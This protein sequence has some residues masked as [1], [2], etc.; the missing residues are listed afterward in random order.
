M[1]AFI[2]NTQTASIVGFALS[3]A[4]AAE[5][6]GENLVVSVST[7]LEGLTNT[8]LTTLYNAFTGETKNQFKTSKSD[9][10]K[11][12]FAALEAM[13]IT[14]MVQL[15]KAEEKIVEVQ[16]AKVEV[17]AAGKKAR[18]IRDSKLQRL[19][20]LF[21]QKNEAGEYKS[22]TIK[23]LMELTAKSSAPEDAVSQGVVNVYLSILRAPKFFFMVIPKETSPEGVTTYT[24]RPTEE[25]PG[26]NLQ[27]V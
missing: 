14:A 2:L 9:S 19:K 23:E 7:D 8:Q 4:A 20:A 5:K 12:V 11:K 10:A 15:D 18:K 6:A 16:A 3:A 13:D 27:L 17:A 22:Y 21:L 26:Q 25:N 24:F 1:T